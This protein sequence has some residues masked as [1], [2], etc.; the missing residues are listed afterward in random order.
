V[1]ATQVAGMFQRFRNRLQKRRYNPYTFPEYLR[2][3]GAQV[4]EGCCIASMNIE[5]GIE[6]Y[7]LKVGNHVTI[8]KDTAVM[9]HDGAAW[10]FRHLV[11]DLQVY[12]PVV[13]D[14]NCY[15]GQGALLCP[16]ITIGANSVVAPKSVV[17]SDVP[18]NTFVMGV[19]A[20]RA[21]RGG[22]RVPEVI[23]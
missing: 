7:L 15:I 11:P 17:I 3:C 1:I 12:G 22:S 5:V 21:D 20:R 16:N 2:A 8:A 10:V 19:P 9:T 14:D 6:A 23:G 4:G 13:I 18:P